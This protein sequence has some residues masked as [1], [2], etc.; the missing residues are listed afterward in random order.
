MMT[1]KSRTK[2]EETIDCA[3]IRVTHFR[4]IYIFPRQKKR[5]RERKTEK[6]DKHLLEFSGRDGNSVNFYIP[7]SCRQY[8]FPDDYCYNL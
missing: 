5:E 6:D 2:E 8:I 7:A 3:P 4:C 1:P